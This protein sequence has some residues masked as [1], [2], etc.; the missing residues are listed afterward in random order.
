MKSIKITLSDKAEKVF[1]KIVYSLPKNEDGTGI[2]TQSQAINYALESIG[3]FEEKMDMDVYTYLSENLITAQTTESKLKNGKLPIPLVS[4]SLP[5][6]IQEVQRLIEILNELK[7][8]EL[9]EIFKNNNQ[10]LITE[11]WSLLR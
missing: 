6:K 2:C 8:R 1:N 5:G 4:G 11:L 10:R 3:E 9:L 7:K